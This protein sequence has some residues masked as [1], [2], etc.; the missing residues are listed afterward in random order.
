M[1]YQ[2]TIWFLLKISYRVSKEF[3]AFYLGQ[4]KNEEGDYIK[5]NQLI[6]WRVF[7][8]NNHVISNLPIMRG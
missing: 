2:L 1:A 5:H 4:F 3:S 7:E 8:T 6:M